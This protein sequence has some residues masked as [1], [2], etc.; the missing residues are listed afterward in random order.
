MT[1]HWELHIYFL[2]PVR[3]PSS[4]EVLV[5]S[6]TGLFRLSVPSLLSF[7]CVFLRLRCP[8]RAFWTCA[9]CAWQR[10]TDR[11]NFFQNLHDH[12]LVKFLFRSHRWF[13]ILQYPST[14]R[15]SMTVSK[16]SI[17]LLFSI[18]N[19]LNDLCLSSSHCLPSSI[20][21]SPLHSVTPGISRRWS[22]L[23]IQQ[24]Q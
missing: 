6:L 8:I 18:D 23:Q 21:N 7:Y 12:V 22:I 20:F 13:E 1:T 15:S 16:L 14:Q 2:V 10:S 17:H 9:K 11:Y 3:Q 5:T 24:S 4:Y 19:D